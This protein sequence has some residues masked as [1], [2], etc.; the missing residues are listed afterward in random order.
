MTIDGANNRFSGTQLRSIEGWRSR[1]WT[2]STDGCSLPFPL[3]LIS[4]KLSNWK[5]PIRSLQRCDNVTDSQWRWVR[6]RLDRNHQI[7]YLIK[8]FHIFPLDTWSG[9]PNLRQKSGIAR[10]PIK[11]GVR[12]LAAN[13]TKVLSKQQLGLDLVFNR[14]HLRCSGNY[15]MSGYDLRQFREVS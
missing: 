14:L 13:G 8:E 12:Q 1:E 5:P 4:P 7:E 11:E 6:Q 2:N 15:L 3:I 10:I 9:L